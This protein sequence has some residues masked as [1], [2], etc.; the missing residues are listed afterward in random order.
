MCL[1]GLADELGVSNAS[2]LQRPFDDLKAAALLLPNDLDGVGPRRWFR[3][4]SSLAWDW[5]LELD[6]QTADGPLPG[7][8]EQDLPAG[9]P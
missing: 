9:L 3:R 6:A 7:S 8:R 2:R 4:A 1:T 5:V